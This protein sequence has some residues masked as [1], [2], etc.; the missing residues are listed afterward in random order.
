MSISDVV[1]L[2]PQ[3]TQPW[4]V[5]KIANVQ[6]HELLSQKKLLESESRLYNE[7]VFDWTNVGPRRPIA[8]QTQED[9]LVKVHEARRNTISYG[10]GFETARR[11]GNL[12]GGS[13]VLPGLPPIGLGNAQISQ[14]EKTFASPRVSF[15][16]TR[17]NLRGLGE[18]ASLATRLARLQ[19]R[20]LFTFGDPHFRGSQWRTLLSLS[21][22]RTSENPL[23][24]ARLFESSFQIERRFK[25]SQTLFLRYR[26][27]RTSLARLLVPELVLPEDRSI[28]LSTLSSSWIRDT[29]D[30]PLDPSRGRYQT[31]DLGINPKFIGQFSSFGP[32]Q[33]IWCQGCSAQRTLFLGR[34]Y[35]FAWLPDKWSRA[36]A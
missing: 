36:P 26:F 6:P 17:R 28:H 14:S 29:R 3:Q 9:V 2:G 4:F 22:E 1:I 27:S 19:Q 20:G 13:I 18:T 23:F 7:G 24:T 25:E 34:Q 12:P 31:V 21:G 11:G 33:A 16:Y 10:F 35:F 8:D 15:E 32:G 5:N 30:K